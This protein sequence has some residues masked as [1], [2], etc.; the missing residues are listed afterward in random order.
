PNGGKL[1]LETENIRLDDDYAAQNLDV[2]PG[3][4][5]MLAV[6][7]TG[8]GM[9]PDVG[10]RAFEPFFA[11][12]PVGA[13]RGLGLSMVYGFVK[14]SGGH[15]KIY[16]EPGHGTTIRLYLPAVMQEAAPAGTV[17]AALDARR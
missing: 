5:A 4:Y 6:S 9:A 2:R 15:I 11:T 14:Q 3:D 8:A 17:S 7:D 12:T 1:I 10:D 13:G 16:S